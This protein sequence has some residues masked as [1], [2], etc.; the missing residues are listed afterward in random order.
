M[1]NEN[2]SA[3]LSVKKR[4][5]RPTN[6]YI[7]GIVGSPTINIKSGLLLIGLW[8]QVDGSVGCAGHLF[9][10][11]N[12][13]EVQAGDVLQIA[14]GWADPARTR[15]FLPD[16]V[17]IPSFLFGSIRIP[18]NIGKQRYSATEG[19]RKRIRWC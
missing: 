13:S 14:M 2:L 5:K 17:G 12:W 6:S 15:S 8:R 1:G 3:G 10:V 4:H 18:T 7:V 9:T 11:T 19:R 16:P